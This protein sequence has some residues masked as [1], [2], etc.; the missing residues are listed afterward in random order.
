MY[1]FCQ[2]ICG[3]RDIHTQKIHHRDI[4]PL[5]VFLAKGHIAK[6]GDFGISKK[7]DVSKNQGEVVGTIHYMAPEIIDANPYLPESDVWSLGVLI[8]EL[9]ALKRPFTDQGGIAGIM[10]QIV[11]SEPKE[12][13]AP[14][15]NDLKALIK[16]MLTKDWRKRPNVT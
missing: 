7:S 15:S 12:I 1:W 2:L 6:I 9:C 5:N 4:K 10:S 13:T 8:Y 16:L 14:F 3:L 11:S